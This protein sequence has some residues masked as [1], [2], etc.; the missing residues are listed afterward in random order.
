MS[1]VSFAEGA[2]VA[3][4][5]AL[6]GSA[7]LA[8]ATPLLGVGVARLLLAVTLTSAYLVYLLARRARRGGR[9]LTVLAWAAL[10]ALCLTLAPTLLMLVASL[11]AGL[12][13]LRTLLF[14]RGPLAALADL[15]LGAVS[16]ALG[17]WAWLASGSLALALWTAGLAQAAHVWL[18]GRRARPRRDAVTDFD[19]AARGAEQALARLSP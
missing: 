5:M 14:A 16:V 10:L 1:A 6:G 15:A 11:V 19:A 9:A 4:A 12:S 17:A 8:V 18:P 2:L 7:L 3:L 13:V